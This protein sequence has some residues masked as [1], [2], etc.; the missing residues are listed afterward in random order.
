MAEKAGSSEAVELLV[1]QDPDGMVKAS[2]LEPQC[3]I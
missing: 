1:C 2:L 3:P